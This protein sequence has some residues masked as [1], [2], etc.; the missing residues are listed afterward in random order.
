MARLLGAQVTVVVWVPDERRTE[1]R[2][3]HS[4]QL[5]GKEKETWGWVR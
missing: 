3:G 4:Q 2:S 1:F 5:H